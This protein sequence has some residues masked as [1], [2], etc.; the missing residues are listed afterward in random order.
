MLSLAFVDV[1]I[2]LFFCFSL[3]FTHTHNL[4]AH[5][6]VC[7]FSL[8]LATHFIWR[9]LLLN[10][11]AY[12]AKV[13]FCSRHH[14]HT[15][16]HAC[17]CLQQHTGSCCARVGGGVCMGLMLFFFTFRYFF[18]VF[19]F[20]VSFSVFFFFLRFILCFRPILVLLLPSYTIIITFTLHFHGFLKLVTH[21]HTP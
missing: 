3:L 10:F 2:G 18:S 5:S 4:R 11:N 14:E 6:V 1:R 15:H 7:A 12:F 17:V 9:W 20:F 8:S 13:L 21:T 16:T 19:F